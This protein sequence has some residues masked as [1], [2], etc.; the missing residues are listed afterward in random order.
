MR[1]MSRGRPTALP[2]CLR[3]GL[4]GR[5][6]EPKPLP[7]PLEMRLMSQGRPPAAVVVGG[8]EVVA[9]E[10]ASASAVSQPQIAAD[11]PVEVR[12]AAS[13]AVP[14]VPLPQ[15]QWPQWLSADTG[16]VSASAADSKGFLRP[17]H[18]SPD[19]A[20][21]QAIQHFEIMNSVEN[22]ES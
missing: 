4:L 1:L 11:A 18:L 12:S 19:I 6:P 15:Q 3:P 8:A 22:A 17:Y 20:A 7:P 2:K 21:D 10:L 16:L 13:E 14:A 9:V 5:R